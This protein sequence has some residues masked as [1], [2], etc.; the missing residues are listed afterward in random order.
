MEIEKISQKLLEACNHNIDSLP[1]AKGYGI[2]NLSAKQIKDIET[3]LIDH[4]KFSRVNWME[5]S[6][7]LAKDKTPIVA[8]SMILSDTENPTYEGQIVYIYRIVFTPRMYDPEKMHIPV[9]EGCVFAPVIV[10]SNTLKSVQSITLTWSPE[11]F[12]DLEAIENSGKDLNQR[13]RD[14]LEKVLTNPKEYKPGGF[15]KCALRFAVV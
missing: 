8:K 10:P 14:L 12:Q 6:A 2:D 1:D 13:V 5:L 7:I 3:I 4:F 15:V 9:K 11:D